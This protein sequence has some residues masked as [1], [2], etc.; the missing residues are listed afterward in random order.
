LTYDGTL[1][2]NE[3][4]RDLK[5]DT[6]FRLL[7]SWYRDASA[8][9]DEYPSEL[10][11]SVYGGC[12]IARQIA[13]QCTLLA[14][15]F[16]RRLHVERILRSAGHRIYPEIKRKDTPL[17]RQFKAHPLGISPAMAHASTMHGR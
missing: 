13:D 17:S 2:A 11:Q 3:K 1:R 6:L 8:Y 4:N 10:N 15:K 14:N 16:S 5:S 9:G 12:P 7:L